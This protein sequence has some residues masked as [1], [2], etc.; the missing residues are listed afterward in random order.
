MPLIS[1][2]KIAPAARKTWAAGFGIFPGV[3]LFNSAV[4]IPGIGRAVPS[5]LG[6]SATAINRN[7]TFG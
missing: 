5:T 4:L 7:Y 2:P 6:M 3:L 1:I